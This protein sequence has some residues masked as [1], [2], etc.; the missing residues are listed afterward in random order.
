MI[1]ETIYTPINPTYL[2]IKQ[3]SIT[4]LKYY[5]KTTQDPYKYSGSGIHWVAHCKKH[6]KRHIKTL[7]VS[8]L[9]YDTSIVEHALN[10]SYKNN[11]VKSTEWANLKPENGLDGGNGA[12]KTFY[13]KLCP[14]CNQSFKTSHKKHVFCSKSCARRFKPI[15]IETRIYYIVNRIEKPRALLYKTCYC[16]NIFENKPSSKKTFCSYSCSN[17]ITNKN[18]IP[19]AI[20]KNVYTFKNTITKEI[21]E[22]TPFD[23][24][25]YS[26]LSSQEVNHLTSYNKKIIKTWTIYDIEIKSFRDEIPDKP[27]V[28][29]SIKECPH[30]N[31]KVSLSNYSRWHGDNCKLI[32]PDQ[33]TISINKLK[34]NDPKI[35]LSE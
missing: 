24:K 21:L 12:E 6:G 23:F 8:D 19:I 35:T 29:Q 27:Y 10:F 18:R 30:C 25:E 31:K 16:G 22:M 5:G 34:F 26:K 15:V 17:K 7:W 20:N 28:P 1:S 4:G 2:Y 32:N 11:I 14:H 13:Y 3:H 33:H 9:Y